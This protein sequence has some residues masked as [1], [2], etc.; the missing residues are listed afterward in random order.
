MRLPLEKVA[1]L[2]VPEL[3]VAV[4]A[5]LRHETQNQGFQD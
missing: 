5:S 1:T 3:G 4:V 2:P